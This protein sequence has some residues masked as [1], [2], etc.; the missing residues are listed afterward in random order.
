MTSVLPV[1]SLGVVSIQTHAASIMVAWRLTAA[2]CRFG[3]MLAAFVAPLPEQRFPQVYGSQDSADEGGGHQRHVRHLLKNHP[4][5][6]WSLVGL[7]GNVI[8]SL[9]ELLQFLG[10]PGGL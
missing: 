10:L 6:A 5:V 4:R 9:T 7:A 3:Y 8:D 1:R 2:G